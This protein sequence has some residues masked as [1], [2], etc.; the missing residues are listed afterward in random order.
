MGAHSG[1]FGVVNG[2]S[3]VRNWTINEVQEAKA[4]VASNTKGGT[5]RI[6]GVHDWSGSFGAYGGQPAAMPGETLAFAGYTAPNDNTVGSDGQRYSGSA[7]VDS[8]AITLNWATGDILSYVLNFSGN[9]ALTKDT[10]LYSD[11]TTP[12]VPPIVLGRVDWLTGTGPDVWT[13]WENIAQ[14]VLTITAAN[15]AYVNSSSVVSG[16]AWRQRLAGIIDFTLAITEQE[17]LRASLPSIGTSEAIRLYINATEFYELRNANLLDFSGITVDRET[18]A[19]TQR[20]VNFG[21]DG[22]SAGVEGEII[23]PDLSTFWP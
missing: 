9:G 2:Q 22:W 18:G 8:V 15:Q 7:I 11:A 10:G 5:G 4:Y 13:E 17:T 19:I 14:A 20:T 3:T 23:L 1:K 21:M 6:K 12:D 16:I